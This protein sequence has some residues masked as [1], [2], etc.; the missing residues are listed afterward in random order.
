[1]VPPASDLSLISLP[2]H[3]A[4]MFQV[5]RQIMPSTC[6]WL[7]PEGVRLI[8][9]FSVAAGGTAD[10]WEAT[11]DGRKIVLKS[12]R[13]YMKFDLTKAVEVR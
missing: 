4:Q 13:Y 10:I 6:R 7:S 12:Y 3:Y 8:G 5:L 11:H 2:E 9:S 1:M